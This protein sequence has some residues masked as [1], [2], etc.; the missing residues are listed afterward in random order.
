MD[1]GDIEVDRRGNG[2]KGIFI[3]WWGGKYKFF[4]RSEL[5]GKSIS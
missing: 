3:L 2:V 1:L 4:K 5:F